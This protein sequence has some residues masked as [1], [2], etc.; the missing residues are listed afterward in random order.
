M[1]DIFLRAAELIETEQS[2][3][4]CYAISRLEE[5]RGAESFFVTWLRPQEADLKGVTYDSFW[6]DMGCSTLDEAKDRRVLALCFAAAICDDLQ[7]H[8][9]CNGTGRE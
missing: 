3:A 5:T 1:R 4:C 7:P 2:C 8:Q 9:P 6:M